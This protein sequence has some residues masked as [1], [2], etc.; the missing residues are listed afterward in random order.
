MEKCISFSGGNLYY[1][2]HGSGYP[3]LLIHGFAEDGEIWKYQIP[4]IEKACKLIVPNIPGSGKSSLLAL[5]NKEKLIDEYAQSVNAILESENI[6]ECAVIGHSMGGY[7]AL[8]L[9]EKYPKEINGLGLFHSTAYSDN[10]EKKNNRLKGIEFIKK[11]GSAEF[12][13]QSTPNLFAQK[14]KENHPEMIED[15]IGSGANFS[16]SCLVQYYAAM[17]TRPDRT[18]VLKNFHK[19][20]LFII[21]DEDK[22]VNLQDSLTQCHIPV[23]S[24]VLILSGV[25]HMGMWEG[26]EESNVAIMKYLTLLNVT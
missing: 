26:I 12:L 8:A 4:V 6:E 2:T 24:Q 23:L 19:P 18:A 25:A 15:L 21:G 9:A 22:S 13:K 1:R 5:D 3:V 20:V 11:H 16:A 17:L 14:F 10:E 7:I